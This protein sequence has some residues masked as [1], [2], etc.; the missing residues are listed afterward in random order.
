MLNNNIKYDD[1]YNLINII[2][3]EDKF[4]ITTSKFQ[5]I[6]I[7]HFKAQFQY[8]KNLFGYVKK[9]NLKDHGP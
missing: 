7:P 3:N 6:D 2:Q 5:E 4:N 1:F 8:C 9:L